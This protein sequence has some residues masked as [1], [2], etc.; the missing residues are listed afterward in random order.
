MKMFSIL[1]L[2]ISSF[3]VSC[4]DQHAWMHPSTS[5][6]SVPPTT[7]SFEKYIQETQ[8]QITS[9]LKVRFHDDLP[10][11]YLGG[12]SL[13]DT[14]EMR[15]PFQI[16][17]DDEICKDEDAEKGFLLIHGLTDSP[18][19]MRDIANSLHNQKIGRAHV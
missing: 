9:A 18:F 12:Y 14:V 2:V 4:T 15:S 16:S 11:P 5:P 17:K 13:E 10:S 6:S 7:L 8:E 19:L 1:L 3:L